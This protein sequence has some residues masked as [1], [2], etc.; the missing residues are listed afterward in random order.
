MATT[1]KLGTAWAM[2]ADFITIEAR[3]LLCKEAKASGTPRT[4][5]TKRAVYAR[6]MWA[7]VASEMVENI[8][9]FHTSW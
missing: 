5:L 8:T 7:V 3:F 9:M 6:I 2:L 4:I 1:A